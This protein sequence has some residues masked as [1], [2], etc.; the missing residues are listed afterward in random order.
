MEQNIGQWKD[1]YDSAEP[2]DFPLPKPYDAKNDLERL[3][4]LRC[5]RMDKL[6]PA[7]QYFIQNNVGKEFIE[8]PPFDLASSYDDSQ[9]G[10]PLIFILSPGSDPMDGL[11]KFANDKGLTGSKLQTISLGQGQGPVAQ[12]MIEQAIAAGT[13]VVLQNCHVA[14]SWMPALELICQDVIT[15]DTVKQSFRLWLTSYPSPD[16]PVTVL[17]NGIKMTNEAPQGLRLNLLRSYLSNPLSDKSFFNSVSHENSKTWHRMVFSLCFFHALVQE[18][19][20]FGP[21]GWNIPYEFNESDLRICLQQLQMFLQDYSTG[22]LDA[23]IYL[24]GECNYGGRVTDD[25]D[26]RLL[27]SLLST[28]YCPEVISMEGYD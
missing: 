17:Q 5:F 21:L 20:K 3:T 4:I 6:I 26:R 2:Q 12:K 9:A 23:L 18:R 27:M 28:F 13:W 7:V 14:T 16:F 25:K 15:S 1:L 10:T 8:P 24:T 22:P 11:M 19:R